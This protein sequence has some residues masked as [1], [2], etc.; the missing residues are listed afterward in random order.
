MAEC[1]D[2]MRVDAELVQR[3]LYAE[4]N[5]FH[6]SFEDEDAR[7]EQE[8]RGGVLLWWATFAPELFSQALTDEIAALVRRSVDS[9]N[10]RTFGWNQTISLC[11][12]LARVCRDPRW[13]AEPLENLAH[14]NSALR[15]Q[16]A[17]ELALVIPCVP[18]EMPALRDAVRANFEAWHFSAGET[19]ALYVASRG[20]KA[21]K[22][23]QLACWCAELDPEAPDYEVLVAFRDR[24]YAPNPFAPFVGRLHRY[25]ALRLATAGRETP[26]QLLGLLGGADGRPA[27]TVGG[28]DV[29][30]RLE[31]HPLAGPYVELSDVEENGQPLAGRSCP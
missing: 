5:R 3:V 21:E 24:G 10:H 28:S 27:S 31:Q 30:R 25:L 16:I 26:V 9:A 4:F 7:E 13:L 18:C 2:R 6:E 8:L 12:V 20:A 1:F 11:G 29:W 19:V 23:H 15:R 14:H 22:M 17:A